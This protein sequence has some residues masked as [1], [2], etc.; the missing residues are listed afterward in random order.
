ISRL[1]VRL[2]TLDILANHSRAITADTLRVVRCREKFVQFPQEVLAA[3][4]QIDQTLYIVGHK[5]RSLPARGLLVH[6]VVV[7]LSRIERFDPRAVFLPSVHKSRGCIEHVP[8]I[9]GPPQAHLSIL[10]L[11]K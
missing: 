2:V 11:P 5:P 7:W 10:F 9:K 4:H 8:G 3:T 6:E 1:L